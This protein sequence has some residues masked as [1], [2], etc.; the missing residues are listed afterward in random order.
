[1]KKEEPVIDQIVIPDECGDSLWDAVLAQQV[2]AS[3][4]KTASGVSATLPIRN[5]EAQ[6]C[7]ATAAK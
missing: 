2:P 1:M 7:D 6:V 5:N 4:I 3:D